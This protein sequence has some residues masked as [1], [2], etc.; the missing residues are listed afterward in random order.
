MRRF[1]LLQLPSQPIA[2]YALLVYVG[3]SVIGWLG[4]IGFLLGQGPPPQW[5]LS[6]H[7]LLVILVLGGMAGMVLQYIAVM[8]VINA[9]TI[10][11]QIE[12][13][14]AQLL[15]KCVVIL[16]RIVAVVLTLY[17]TVAGLV[18]AFLFLPL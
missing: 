9:R 6:K 16:A 2:R 15:F 5:T 11:T 12:S 10:G 4:I 8:A 7:Q 13:R 1:N 17:A 3:V 14:S 18:V